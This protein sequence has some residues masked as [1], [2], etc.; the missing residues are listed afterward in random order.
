[1]FRI[2]PKYYNNNVT[3]SSRGTLRQLQRL[4]LSQFRPD[5]A[6]SSATRQVCGVQHN[7]NITTSNVCSSAESTSQGYY[8]LVQSLLAWDIML[9]CILDM[10]WA[11]VANPKCNQRIFLTSRE[12]T[13]NKYMKLMSCKHECVLAVGGLFTVTV[14]QWLDRYGWLLITS[15][16]LLI[17]STISQQ[18]T[19]HLTHRRSRLCWVYSRSSQVN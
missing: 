17:T 10:L 7:N 4:S 18:Q 2:I 19:W 6:G 9:S 1:M 12:T 14:A 15:T 11:P 8:V 16:I 13:R 5:L 3:S